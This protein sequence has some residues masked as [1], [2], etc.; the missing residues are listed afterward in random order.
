MQINGSA[1]KQKR[2]IIETFHFLTFYN[3]FFQ[4]RKTNLY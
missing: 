3:Y 4:F 1:F 2:E